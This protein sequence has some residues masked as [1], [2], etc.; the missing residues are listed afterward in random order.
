METAAA[1]PRLGARRKLAIGVGDLGFNLY[2]QIAS[3]YLLFFYTDVLR[4]PPATAGAIYMVA[5]IWD[6]V[7]DPVIGLLVDRTRSRFG[8]YRPYLLFGSPALALAFVALFIVPTWPAPGSVGIAV[9][10]HFLFRTLYAVVSVPYAALNARVTR[11]ASDRA[12]ITGV[13]MVCATLSAVFVATATLPLAGWFGNGQRGWTAVA[14]LYGA[15]AT[16]I[17]LVTARGVRGLD[18]PTDIVETVPSITAKLRATAGNVPLFLILGGVALTSF[19]NTIF[20]KN[21]LYYFKYAV[22][23]PKLGGLAL[24][25]CAL[26][27]ALCVPIWVLVARRAGKRRAWL[28][29]LVPTIAGLILW[30]LA[31]GHGVLAL[32]VALAVLSVGN[33]AYYVAFWA[34]VPDTVEY[35]EWRSGLRSESLAFGL[36]MLGQKAALGLGAGFLG[37]ALAHIGYVADAAQSPQTLAAIKAMMFWIPFAAALLTG[38]LIAFYPISP[39]FHRR[40]VAEIAAR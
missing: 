36:L 38:A 9:M 26:I 40:M 13:R 32:F 31:D 1:I 19:A 33:A 37:M 23:D 6:A 12:D 35:A 22:G 39:A 15:L 10:T 20:Q 16:L 27:A 30:R 28:A 17:L 2:W 11:D 14:V 5:L 29:G 18:A 7:L 3:L 21:L 34:M 8:R 4:L 24:G 25:F